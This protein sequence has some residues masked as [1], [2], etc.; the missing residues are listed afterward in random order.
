MFLP[1]LYLFL[2]PFINS[3]DTNDNRVRVMPH[4]HVEPLM[5]GPDG[6]VLVEPF[7][8]AYATFLATQISDIMAYFESRQKRV[9]GE[10]T[11]T[12]VPETPPPVGAW[13]TPGSTSWGATS[14]PAGGLPDATLQENNRPRSGVII[15][16]T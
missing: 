7:S 6:V 5:L 9:T 15:H 10:V 8:S 12:D 3:L 11:I 16:L 14:T 2:K 13:G 4:Y 1:Y